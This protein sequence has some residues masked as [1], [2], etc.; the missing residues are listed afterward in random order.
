MANTLIKSDKYDLICIGEIVFDS[1]CSVKKDSKTGALLN[2]VNK[3]F[4][5]R[6][7]NVTCY[8][9]VFGLASLLVAPVGKDF[10]AIGG[11]EYM[12]KRD[13]SA[14][15]LI[16]SKTYDTPMAFVFTKVNDA[17]TYFYEG[18]LHHESDDYRIHSIS[19]LKRSPAKALFCT[20]SS[21][22][23]NVLHLTGSRGQLRV[24]APAH[25][26]DHYTEAQL[27]E[28]LSHTDMFFL[29]EIEADALGQKL[30][31]DVS[32]IGMKFGVGLVVETI[33]K[34]GSLLFFDGKKMAVPV[35]KPEKIVDTT[36]AG[37]SYAAAFVASYLKK[38][39]YVYSAKVASAMASYIIEVEGAQGAMPTEETVLS[40]ARLNYKD[41]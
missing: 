15:G 9:S 23:L 28:C 20:S 12:A 38:K 10:R 8:A 41:L 6:G 2:H 32:E 30:K 4:G 27:N 22:A 21:P 1:I 5:G 36:G 35:C 19:V 39:D 14:D 13:L 16:T 3:G 24:F 17:K 25:E 33:G 31:I 29:N 34:N 37:D 18:P 26:L 40:R 7:A 11:E